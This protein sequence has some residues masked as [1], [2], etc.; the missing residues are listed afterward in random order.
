MFD[1]LTSFDKPFNQAP[2]LHIALLV[3]LWVV[4]ARYVPRWLSWPLH[5]WFALIGVS[6]LTTYQ[7]HFF[8]LPTGAA[9]GF[10]A[11]WLWPDRMASPVM[12]FRVTHAPRRIALALY[13]AA[14]AIMT[15]AAAIAIGGW[16]WWLFWPSFS[17]A[18]V[19]ANY[20]FLGPDGFEKG[21]DGRMTLGAIM[22]F[23]PYLLA[24]KINSRL[25][26]G[27]RHAVEIRD[28]VHISG[29]PSRREAA[30]FATVIDLC[31]ELPATAVPAQCR[32]LPMLDLA[33]PEPHRL[34]EAARLIE[35]ARPR[36][37]VLVCC[38]LGFS[39]STAAIATWL[40][41]HGRF[42]SADA[43]E[44]IRRVWPYVRLKM[45]ARAAIEEAVRGGP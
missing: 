41:I 32:A 16:G 21:A 24:A 2:S 42:N 26:R 35:E 38:A 39:R 33:T 23:L 11:L 45:A 30:R 5:I 36:G 27:L 17:L 37:P 18:L 4:Y 13:Y 3:V 14:G 34:R 25:W 8:D 12:R 1:A 6:V 15:A 10:F 43:I 44:E 20:A 7:H 9:L 22:L 29:L 31:A 40:A 28:G 19:A